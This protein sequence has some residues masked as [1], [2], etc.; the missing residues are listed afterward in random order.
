MNCYFKW[1]LYCLFAKYEVVISKFCARV[2]PLQAITQFL[3]FTTINKCLLYKLFLLCRLLSD[4]RLK[5]YK[6]FSY[7]VIAPLPKNSQYGPAGLVFGNTLKKWKPS[8]AGTLKSTKVLSS[9]FCGHGRGFKPDQQYLS[10]VAPQHQQDD[11]PVQNS[12][13]EY[14]CVVHRSQVV[15]LMLC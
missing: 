1:T 9:Y 5:F 10:V 14:R 6:F 4:F 13:L 8:G 3:K 7:F 12:N 11:L 2:L 15:P